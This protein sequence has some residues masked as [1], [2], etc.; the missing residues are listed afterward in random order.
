M[1]PGI[2]SAILTLGIEERIAI[3][4]LDHLYQ[5]FFWQD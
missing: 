5:H 4:V 3:A 2:M 1:N